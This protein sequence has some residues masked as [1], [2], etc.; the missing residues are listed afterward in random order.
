MHERRAMYIHTHIHDLN[1][2]PILSGSETPLQ[3][4]TVVRLASEICRLSGKAPLPPLCQIHLN[5]PLELLLTSLS[6]APVLLLTRRQISESS[7]G[8]GSVTVGVCKPARA[9]VHFFPFA[10]RRHRATT[11]RGDEPI[12]ATVLRT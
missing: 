12:V 5:P 4:E 10:S 6:G 1:L 7:D 11:T 2:Q 8:E 9:R 3:S